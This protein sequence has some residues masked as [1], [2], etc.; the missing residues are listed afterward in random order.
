MR[1]EDSFCCSGLDSIGRSPLVGSTLIFPWLLRLLSPS[2]GSCLVPS[3]LGNQCQEQVVLGLRR[4]RNRSALTMSLGF[5]GHVERSEP[6]DLVMRM[7]KRGGS[8]DNG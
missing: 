5:S 4:R 3:G 1:M 2:S 8:R 6:A 7:R